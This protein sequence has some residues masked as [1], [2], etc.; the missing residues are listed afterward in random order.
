MQSRMASA[1]NAKK[2]QTGAD[3][4]LVSDNDRLVF[5]L[6]V[7]LAVH[8]ILGLGV[9]FTPDDPR[10]ASQTLEVT[11]AR[12]SDEKAPEKADFLAETNQLGSGDQ[13]KAV[14]M[15]SPQPQETLL[16]LADQQQPQ[17][18]AMRAGSKRAEKKQQ[19]VAQHAKTQVVL[20][21]PLEADAG[22]DH[23][24]LLER[25]LE[26][27]SLQARLD[28]QQRNYAKRPRVMRV[29]GAST[30][31]SDDAWY[32]RNW[33]EKVTRVGNLNYPDEARKRGIHGNVRVLVALYPS[34]AVKEISI[35]ESSGYSVLD[36]AAIRIIRQAAP[37]APFTEA[38][39][40]EK[41]ILEVIRTWSFQ[42][43]GLSSG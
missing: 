30:L 18:A 29:T 5:T 31:Q 37:F 15:T 14:E 6:F 10:H 21:D 2:Q 38:M 22:Q 26:M 13:D 36:D 20:V 39:R 27:A 7:A 23:K 24:T 17:P 40:A 8:A 33:T 43:R 11:L 16:A 12:F 1:K 19:L 25:S 28:M 34:G 32:V 35:M 3:Q 41:D 4:A 9:A 42:S